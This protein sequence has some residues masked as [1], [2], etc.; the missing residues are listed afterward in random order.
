MEKSILTFLKASLQTFFK[1]SLRTRLPSKASLRSRLR[2]EKQS[3]LTPYILSI[4]ILSTLTSIAQEAKENFKKLSSIQGTWSMPTKRGTVYEN[5]QLKDNV[6]DG[7]SYKVIGGD[8]IL[9]ERVTILIKGAE[10]FY[11]PLVEGQNNGE[12]VSFKLVSSLNDRFIFD[13]PAHDF[14][15]RV[16][17][18]LPKSDAMHAWIEGMDKGVYRKSD[19]YYKRVK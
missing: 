3:A 10:I 7:K 13:N 15:Q 14:P 19:F 11:I 2:R 6:L 8:T 16:I 5:W 9:L 12:P 4:C 1:A 17:Y 18:E